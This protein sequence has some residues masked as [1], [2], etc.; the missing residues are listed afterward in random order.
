MKCSS[1]NVVEDKFFQCSNLSTYSIV[2]HE[3]IMHRKQNVQWVTPSYEVPST[4]K[5]SINI[6]FKNTL[7]AS[8]CLR[9]IMVLVVTPSIMSSDGTEFSS[10]TRFPMSIQNIIHYQNVNSKASHMDKMHGAIRMEIRP[11]PLHFCHVFK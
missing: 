7:V 5:L 1:Q 2:L 10:A 6:T 4:L 3:Y 8:M 11:L 9:T